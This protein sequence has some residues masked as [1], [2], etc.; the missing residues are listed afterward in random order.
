MNLFEDQQKTESLIAQER[1]RNVERSE[2]ILLDVER[3]RAI[4]G[5]NTKVALEIVDRLQRAIALIP[6]FAESSREER[7][8]SFIQA[9]QEIWPENDNRGAYT[10]YQLN[11]LSS[12][13]DGVVLRLAP[14]TLNA[15][16][17]H[18]LRGNSVIR[19]G[20]SRLLEAIPEQIESIQDLLAS[21]IIHETEHLI[22]DGDED[23]SGG[24]DEAQRFA[25]L[26]HPG[27]MRAHAKMFAYLFDQHFPGEEF[28][29]EKLL[30][31]SIFS[32]NGACNKYYKHMAESNNAPQKTVSQRM[33]QLAEWYLAHF[34]EAV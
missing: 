3:D 19:L 29:P 16:L 6:N 20:L 5:E 1:V 21:Y 30:S 9:F 17:G 31:L 2:N 10:A 15:S 33:I 27:E 23:L 13:M 8:K 22:A 24:E 32:A 26:S 4:E 34:Q 28:Q 11:A 7:L 25:Y 14:V 18:D 12:K